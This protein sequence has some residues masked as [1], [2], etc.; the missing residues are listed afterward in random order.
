MDELQRI[1]TN[2]LFGHVSEIKKPDWERP[3]LQAV[4]D[5]D[6]LLDV[7]DKSEVIDLNKAHHRTKVY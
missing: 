4:L 6:S 5:Q 3:V 1:F 7:A 2:Q